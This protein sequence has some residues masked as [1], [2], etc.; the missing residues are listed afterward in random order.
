M[1]FERPSVSSPESCRLDL[2]F[3]DVTPIESIR[4][5]MPDAKFINGTGIKLLL[6]VPLFNRA[7]SYDSGLADICIGCSSSTLTNQ[8][9]VV[10]GHRANPQLRAIRADFPTNVLVLIDAHQPYEAEN[11][12]QTPHYADNLYVSPTWLNSIAEQ[13]CE[14]QVATIKVRSDLF[15]ADPVL[16][17]VVRH[18]ARVNR[19][20]ASQV[21]VDTARHLLAVN[22]LTRHASGVPAKRVRARPLSPLMLRKVVEFIDAGISTKLSLAQL[23]QVARMSE[24]QFLRCFSLATGMTPHQFILEKRISHADRLLRT[25]R[26][27]IAQVAIEAGFNSQAHLS[28]VFRARRGTT[29]GTV[30]REH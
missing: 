29:P 20:G 1:R 24:H 14:K 5:R 4:E 3:A 13:M 10:K 23:A 18:F 2:R 15:V 22:L 28:Q 25:G 27:P 9:M 11:Q 7:A 16:N 12:C 30:R 8:T 17:G 21:D 6:D 26:A 19:R